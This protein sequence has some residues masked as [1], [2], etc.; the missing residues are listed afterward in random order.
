MTIG[1]AIGFLVWCVLML[2][3]LLDV[4]YARGRAEW[5]ALLVL[6]G[7]GAAIGYLLEVW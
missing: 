6:V 3:V 2:A 4:V 1:A 7:G 5:I